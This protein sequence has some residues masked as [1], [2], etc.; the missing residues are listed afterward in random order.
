M[1]FQHHSAE[2]QEAAN[3]LMEQILGTAKTNYSEGRLNR[4]DDG[5]LAFACALDK[6][7]NVIIIHFGKTVTWV[8]LN[9]HTA[10]NLR[11]LLN[12]KIK[13]MA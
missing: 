2:E 3:R 8:G 12:E 5:D 10:V 4:E 11:N 9:K 13:E 6:G 1:S 7:N